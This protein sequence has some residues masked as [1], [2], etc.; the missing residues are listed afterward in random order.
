MQRRSDLTSSASRS[1]RAAR[2]EHRFARCPDRRLHHVHG[3]PGDM[4]RRP[5]RG[6]AC[7][8]DTPTLRT[9]WSPRRQHPRQVSGEV[10]RQTSKATEPACPNGWAKR[11]SLFGQ[12]RASGALTLDDPMGTRP[13]SASQKKWPHGSGT[14]VPHGTVS[15]DSSHHLSDVAT[16]A[17]RERPARTAPIPVGSQSRCRRSPAGR[18]VDATPRI[19]PHRRRRSSSLTHRSAETRAAW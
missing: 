3:I 12:L 17:K 14:A 11:E 6:P 5:S 8:R 19:P 1:S 16:D 7:S 15:H 2:D 9:R 13:A 18:P 10:R 4:K